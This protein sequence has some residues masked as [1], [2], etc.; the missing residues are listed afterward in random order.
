MNKTAEEI[1]RLVDV[2]L[3]RMEP[4]LAERVRRLL[5]VPYCVTREWDYPAERQGHREYPCWTILEHR[6]SNTGVA[7]CEFGFGPKAPWGLV[8]LSGKN[9]SRGMD[10]GWFASLA[11]AFL[12]SFAADDRPV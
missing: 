8:W 4:A 11:D 7:Y 3:S 12:D 10:S 2:E 6:P 9:M 1:A 5:V